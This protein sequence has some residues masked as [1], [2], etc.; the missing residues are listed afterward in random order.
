MGIFKL[1][2]LQKEEVKDAAKGK[3]VQIKKPNREGKMA[4]AA[5]VRWRYTRPKSS[6]THSLSPSSSAL[7]IMEFHKKI[8]LWL[9]R[10]CSSLLSSWKNDTV[11]FCL[12]I[13]L[14]L[15]ET[16]LLPLYFSQVLRWILELK[17]CAKCQDESICIYH[18]DNFINVVLAY[19]VLLAYSPS[20]IYCMI[21]KR[22]FFFFG[23]LDVN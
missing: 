9:V 10:H 21:W 14:I 8:N 3:H 7:R 22:V 16:V 13:L 19:F 1:L 2:L 17:K 18:A 23:L 11:Q 5:Q 4:I 15:G 6:V 12:F 20:A